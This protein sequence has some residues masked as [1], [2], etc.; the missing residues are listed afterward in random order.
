[1]S[2]LLLK[3]TKFEQIAFRIPAIHDSLPLICIVDLRNG[4]LLDIAQKIDTRRFQGT[5]Y[6][7][8]FR[9]PEGHM[10]DALCVGVAQSFRPRAFR[11]SI[12]DQFNAGAGGRFQIGHIG[13]DFLKTCQGLDPL[14]TD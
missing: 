8:K 12:P 14:A 1:M 4:Y 11:R 9:D 6:H 3:C 10:P 7:I 2:L 5:Y 13:L